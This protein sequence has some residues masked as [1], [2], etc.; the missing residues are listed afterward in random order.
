M[1]WRFKTVLLSGDTDFVLSCTVSP[2]PRIVLGVV[3]THVF[4]VG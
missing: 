4:S 2:G 1:L 3:G